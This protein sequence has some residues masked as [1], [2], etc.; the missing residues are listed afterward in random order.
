LQ[1]HVY[2]P[3]GVAE[4]VDALLRL[5]DT[6][7]L[8]PVIMHEFAIKPP[9]LAGWTPEEVPQLLLLLL[10]WAVLLPKAAFAG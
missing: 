3:A 1:L 10:P 6:F 7:L 8:M 9:D 5:S 4:Y 2:G